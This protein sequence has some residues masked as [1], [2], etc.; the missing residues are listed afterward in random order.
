MSLIVDIDS[1][2]K[3]DGNNTVAVVE[4]VIHKI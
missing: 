4:Q 2:L 1:G 3:N